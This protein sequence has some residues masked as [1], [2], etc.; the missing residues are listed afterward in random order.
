MFHLKKKKERKN[1]PFANLTI[2]SVGFAF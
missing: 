2:P 1:L